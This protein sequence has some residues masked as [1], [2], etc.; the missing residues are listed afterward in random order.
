MTTTDTDP[1]LNDVRGA[2]KR[3]D[4]LMAKALAAKNERDR[5]ILAAR[6]A[7]FSLRRIGEAGGM[8]HQTVHNVVERGTP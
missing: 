2:A 3:A 6:A 1:V 7:G 4:A 5:A 8:S